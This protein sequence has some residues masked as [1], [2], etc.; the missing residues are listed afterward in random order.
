MAM[1]TSESGS[2][3]NRPSP[4]DLRRRS[5][6][7]M[8]TAA[9]IPVMQSQAGKTLLTGPSDDSGP[10]TKGKPAAQLTV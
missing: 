4:V 3:T 5:A 7:R 9:V 10:V 2:L 6:A 1:A 8:P